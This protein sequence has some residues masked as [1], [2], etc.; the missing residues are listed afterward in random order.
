V[1]STINQVLGRD[2]GFTVHGRGGELKGKS[3]PPVEIR[4]VDGAEVA[5]QFRR[6][7]AKMSRERR[8]GVSHLYFNPCTTLATRYPD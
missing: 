4:F 7:G 3:L 5:D 2:V 6:E 1:A 8:P